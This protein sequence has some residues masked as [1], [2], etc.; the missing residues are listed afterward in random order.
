[1]AFRRKAFLG[2]EV[3]VEEV[4]D[5]C[6]EIETPLVCPTSLMSVTVFV[7]G[8]CSACFSFYPYSPMNEIKSRVRGLE[9]LPRTPLL[10]GGQSLGLTPKRVPTNLYRMSLLKS[11]SFVSLV[12]ISATNV[13]VAAMARYTPT[14]QVLPPAALHSAVAMMGARAAPRMELTL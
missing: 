9:M 4:G 1:M 11:M 10:S 7:P 8:V 2:V 13:S 5:H 12:M 3:D 14:I 6:V